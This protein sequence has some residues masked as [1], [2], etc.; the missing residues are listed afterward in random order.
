[1]E[2]D[3]RMTIA[4]PKTQGPDNHPSWLIR[5]FR[6][7]SSNLSLKRP[8]KITRKSVISKSDIRVSLV[9]RN[10]MAGRISGQ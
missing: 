5:H 9:W 1:M 2:K 4:L 7:V 3:R 8:E 10:V 6:P